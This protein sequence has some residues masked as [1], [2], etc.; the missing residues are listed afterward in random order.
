MLIEKQELNFFGGKI[1]NFKNRTESAFE[2]KH[3][4]SFLRG[5]SRFIFGKD[6]KNNPI[7]FPVLRSEKPIL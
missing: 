5:D 3:L 2:K 6:A 1:T 4:K 7:C